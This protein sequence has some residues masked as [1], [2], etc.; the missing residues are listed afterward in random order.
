M[1]A[2]PAPPPGYVVTYSENFTKAASLGAWRAQPNGNAPV[3][4]SHSYGLGVELTGPEQWSEV[5]DT[6][7]VIGPSSF[8]TALMYV[9]PG[10]KDQVAN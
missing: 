2:V 9:P 4:L 10:G 8:V 6:G 5:A 3:V 7:A 1:M